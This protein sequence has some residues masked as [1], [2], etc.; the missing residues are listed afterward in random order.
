MAGRPARDPQD[1]VGII[2]G[3]PVHAG[4]VYPRAKSGPTSTYSRNANWSVIGYTLRVARSECG[5]EDGADSNTI[6]ASAPDR[7]ATRN[8][9]SKSY[10][11]FVDSRVEALNLPTEFAAWT[12]SSWSVVNKSKTTATRSTDGG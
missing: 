3:S 9:F 11:E 4:E 2:G 6:I 1:F 10:G 7:A 5:R 8:A 12:T